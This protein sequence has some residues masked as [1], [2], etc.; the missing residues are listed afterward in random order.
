MR[1]QSAGTGIGHKVGVVKALVVRACPQCRAPGTWQTPR[2][3]SEANALTPWPAV[4]VDRV[5]PRSGQPVG[6]VCPQCGGE[7]AGLV[8]DRGV[9]ARFKHALFSLF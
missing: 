3:A 6:D 5:D 4:W 9:I 2:S 7:R 1:E 8:E